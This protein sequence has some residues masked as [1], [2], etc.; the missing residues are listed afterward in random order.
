MRQRRPGSPALP[1]C[2]RWASKRWPQ[3]YWKP[4]A[5]A[6]PRALAKRLSK[7]RPHASAKTCPASLLLTMPQQPGEAPVEPSA[8]Q[9]I[10]QARAEHPAQDVAT[11]PAESPVE[12]APLQ[13][14]YLIPP[15]RM[16]AWRSG[17]IHCALSGTWMQTAASASGRTS[18]SSSPGPH[19]SAAFGRPWSEI[20]DELKLDPTNQV[21]RA[22]ASQRNLERHRRPLAGRRFPPNRCRSNCP[23]C[24]YLI[25]TAGFAAIVASASA[26]TSTRINQLARARRDQPIGFRP[27]PEAPQQE[28]GATPAAPAMPAA[29]ADRAGRGRSARRTPSARR[30]LSRR[31]RPMLCRFVSQPRQNPKWRQ[32]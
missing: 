1:R 16:R 32:P 27:A 29:V 18:S 2:R 8:S 13:R 20:A 28:E 3:P 17:G 31:L 4:A 25:A 30:S 9:G 10:E 23:A 19:T 11:A 7:S 6:A 24:R 5:P 14:P 21:V 12:A 15:P 26:V 22:V